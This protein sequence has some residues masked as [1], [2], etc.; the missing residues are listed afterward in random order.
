MSVEAEIQ[1]GDAPAS[2]ARSLAQGLAKRS[3]RFLRSI[4]SRFSS[5]LTRRI[6]VL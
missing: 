4:T 5:S 1:T 3:R 6:L 2:R